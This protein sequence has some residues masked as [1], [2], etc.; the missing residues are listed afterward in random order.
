MKKVPQHIGIILDGNRR[1]ARARSKPTLFGHQ[2]GFEN[3]KTIAN[4]AYKKGVKILTVYAFSTENWNRS[5]EEVSYL[6]DLFKLMVTKEA[7]ELHKNGIKLNILGDIAA[8][9]QELQSGIKKAVEKTKDNTKG[10]LNVCLNYGGRAEIINA[11]KNIIKDKISTDKLD[12][13]LFEKYLY[14]KDIPDPELIIRTSGEQRLSGFL[15]WQSVYSEFYFP[16]KDWP[17]FTEKDLDKAIEEFQKRGRR[18]GGN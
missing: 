1:W 10:A 11:V 4:H 13:K 12:E 6:M 9:D 8:F 7:E 5:K 14:T 17:A 16:T 15:T 18:F 3:L 2:K